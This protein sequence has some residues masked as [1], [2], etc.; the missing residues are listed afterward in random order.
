VSG[1]VV[2]EMNYGQLV[3]EVERCAAGRAS[4][5]SLP[6]TGGA[7]HLPEDILAAILELAPAVKE[8]R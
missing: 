8:T 3:L 5:L 4:T 1:F 2:P 7:V 6:H